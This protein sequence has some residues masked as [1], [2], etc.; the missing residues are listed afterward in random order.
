[1]ERSEI[2]YSNGIDKDDAPASA[3][4][5]HY[6]MSVDAIRKRASKEKWKCS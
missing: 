4:S 1:M 5:K 3:V 6:G 2:C